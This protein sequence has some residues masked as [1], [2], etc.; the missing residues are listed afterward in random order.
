MKLFIFIIGTGLLFVGCHVRIQ[1][2]G[3]IVSLQKMAFT[4]N[5]WLWGLVGATSHEV[6]RDCPL[7]LVYEV[8]LYSR[9]TQ[10]AL[11]LLSLGVYT[12]RTLEVICSGNGVS[13]GQALPLKKYHEVKT[14]TPTPVHP[15]GKG[16]LPT[17]S[18]THPLEASPSEKTPIKRRFEMR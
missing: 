10:A 5:F 2:P 9:P 17:P 18:Q 8:H 11:S 7:G 15:E 4:Q 12:P 3:E 14:I 16:R 6:Y 1:Y 13:E